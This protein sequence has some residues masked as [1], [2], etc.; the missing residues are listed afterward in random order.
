MHIPA[1]LSR[2]CLLKLESGCLRFLIMLIHFAPHSW[3]YSDL[4]FGILKIDMVGSLCLVVLQ[5]QMAQTIGGDDMSLNLIYRSL[6]DRVITAPALFF[7]RNNRGGQVSL[8]NLEWHEQVVLRLP[9]C[10]N[11]QQLE[12]QFIVC[13]LYS[14]NIFSSAAQFVDRELSGA[15]IRWV[16]TQIFDWSKIMISNNKKLLV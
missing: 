14:S 2:S 8:M 9:L 15:R 3:S 7:T 16:K 1:V 12:W 10:W 11:L 5:P 4:P 6:V 13:C